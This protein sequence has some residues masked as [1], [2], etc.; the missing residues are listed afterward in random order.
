MPVGKE[1]DQEGFAERGARVIRRARLSLV[2]S[3]GH[4]WGSRAYDDELHD[5]ADEP[6]EVGSGGPPFE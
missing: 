6:P 2:R 5:A 4:G 1:S 3:F